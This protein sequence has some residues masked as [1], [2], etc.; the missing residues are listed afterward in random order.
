MDILI[1]YGFLWVVFWVVM[2]SLLGSMD[3]CMDTL[4]VLYGYFMD[5]LWD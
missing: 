3:A 1:F 2:G 5:T 4:S